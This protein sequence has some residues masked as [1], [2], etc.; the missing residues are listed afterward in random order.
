[1]TVVSCAVEG[2]LDE[3][4]A[5][6]V[7]RHVGLDSGRVY[8]RMGKQ[9]LRQSIDGYAHAARH[10]PWFVLVDLDEEFSCG[11]ELVATWLPD[12]PPML[13]LR[14]AVREA[15]AWLL[16]DRTNLARFL[17][18]SRDLIPHNPEGL[19]DPKS[20]LVEIARRSRTRSLRE[21]LPPRLDSGRSIG[22]LYVTELSR[23]VSDHWDV[24][25]AASMS[26]SLARCLNALAAMP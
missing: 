13:T 8:G 24:D 2:D 7:L 21:G 19:G 16:G 17:N 3:A 18:V 23:F 15:E 9:H 22:P 1:M 20:L 4:I 26:N 14:V 11:G 5:R 25:A 10:H 12:R 6:R